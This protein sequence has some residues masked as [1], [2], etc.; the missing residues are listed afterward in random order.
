MFSSAVNASFV[1]VAAARIPKFLFSPAFDLQFDTQVFIIW[2]M[3]ASDGTSK[4]G[5]LSPKHANDRRGISQMKYNLIAK[6][7]AVKPL[8]KKEMV[9]YSF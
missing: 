7:L 1:I 5:N 4:T 6:A 8:G 9:N 3:G 2:A